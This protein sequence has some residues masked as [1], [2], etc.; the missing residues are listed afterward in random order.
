MFK[1]EKENVLNWTLSDIFIRASFFYYP[2]IRKFNWKMSERA[3]W[4]NE[5]RKLL[6]DKISSHNIERQFSVNPTLSPRIFSS[7]LKTRRCVELFKMEN[8]QKSLCVTE[9]FIFDEK[10]WIEKR[11]E[12][13]NSSTD[14]YVKETK[15][16]LLSLHIMTNFL[17]LENQTLKISSGRVDS[18]L[19]RI[20]FS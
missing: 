2:T 20:L 12:L 8:S 17:A 1:N 13:V 19:L 6:K 18:S 15:E 11:W 4:D 14:F 16:K 7:L 5:R 10:I 3:K 9:Y